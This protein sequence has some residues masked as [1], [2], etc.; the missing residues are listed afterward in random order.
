MAL[1]NGCACDASGK[2]FSHSDLL[3]C[4]ES[5]P[6]VKRTE[7]RRS[8]SILPSYECIKHRLRICYN[9]YYA[10]ESSS[11]GSLNRILYNRFIMRVLKAEDF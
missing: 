11:K 3:K 6:K 7:S 9:Y 1:H 10:N 2:G 8:K 5:A 4:E